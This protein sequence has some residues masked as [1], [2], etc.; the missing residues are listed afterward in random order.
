MGSYQENEWATSFYKF[1]QNSKAHY[2]FEEKHI[3]S[4]IPP[5]QN[6]LLLG[7]AGGR[8][9]NALTTKFNN[10]TVIDISEAILNECRKEFEGNINYVLSDLNEPSIVNDQFDFIL[11]SFILHYIEDIKTFFE[12]INN[13]LTSSGKCILSIPHPEYSSKLP[14]RNRK[15]LDNWTEINTK[16][17]Y[18]HRACEDYEK[19]ITQ[20][21]LRIL[22]HF[23]TK[24]SKRN[25]EYNWIIEIVKS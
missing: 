20:N 19:A 5:G 23:S 21:K 1:I 12:F 10:V 3:T 18:Y 7:C 8:H 16:M 24:P 6:A 4:L 22:N 13:R 17:E 14:E 25:F 15:V 11:G 2:D 9:I